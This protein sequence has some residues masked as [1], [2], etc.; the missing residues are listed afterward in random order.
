MIGKGG[1]GWQT[2]TAD[3]ALILFL[4]VSAASAPNATT[5]GG[6]PMEAGRNAVST[7]ETAPS[8]AVYRATADTTLTQ[9]L[10]S[11]PMDDRQSVTV[12][13]KR[14]PSGP[15][16]SMSQGVAYLDEVEASG[17]VGR[18]LVQNASSEDVMAVLTY[19]GDANSGMVF[20]D[21]R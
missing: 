18:L 6:V 4:V 12:I 10:A 17:R 9:W 20:A 7:T 3:L 21:R 15:S 2:T 1:S 19:D 14:A 8:T 16:H 11:Q 13:V 5:P